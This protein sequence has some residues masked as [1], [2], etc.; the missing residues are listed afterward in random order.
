[1]DFKIWLAML[2]HFTMIIEFFILLQFV[3]YPNWLIG[4]P[5]REW[6]KLIYSF[7]YLH[8]TAEWIFQKY[9]Y[10][11]K[12]LSRDSSIYQMSLYDIW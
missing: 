7:I 11:L 2:C 9:H 6:R 4:I 8:S 3:L 5:Y 10:K 12:K 1:M